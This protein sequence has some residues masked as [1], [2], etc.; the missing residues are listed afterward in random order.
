MQI[1]DSLT[2]C[3]TESWIAFWQNRT[4]YLPV[5]SSVA[6][7]YAIN[8]FVSNYWQRKFTAFAIKFG[9]GRK[10]V[11]GLS[12][13][14]PTI[15]QAMELNQSFPTKRF[16]DGD[17]LIFSMRQ[18]SV[19]PYQ[20][21]SVIAVT[22]KGAPAF[23]AKLAVGEH[24]DAMV[25]AESNCLQQLSEIDELKGKLPVKLSSGKSKA[26]RAYFATSVA[27]FL[28][29][30]NSFTK[31]HAEFLATLSLA[32][33]KWVK[34]IDS[35]EYHFNQS[36][37][38]RLKSELGQ[39]VYDELQL[40]TES[41]IS[42]I[43]SIEIP[44]VLAHRDF[45]PWNIRWS[46]SGIFVFDW[47]YAASGANPLYDFFHFHL[48]QLAL[49]KKQLTPTDALSL[50]AP[51]LA[52]LQKTFPKY[53]WEEKIVKTLLLVYLVNLIL[54]YVDSGKIYDET[55]PVLSSYYK[56]IAKRDQW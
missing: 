14:W 17:L 42:N 25:E 32:T 46:D 35:L 51:S 47:E 45:A 19:G 23:Y 5:G 1:T 41:A 26:G 7:R 37:L 21:M 12:E 4:L 44:T 6:Q 2:N 48:I 36:A 9:F 54:F 29:V 30:N 34:Y 11:K 40:A 18:G 13:D 33:V 24:A 53:H 50:I 16:G 31:Q 15:Q 20:K 27:P 3:K 49:S 55:H 8:F 28:T 56:L 39:S 38:V 43:G 22:E 52:F 10:V